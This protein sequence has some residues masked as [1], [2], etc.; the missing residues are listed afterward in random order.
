[1]LGLV[2][3]ILAIVAAAG[4]VAWSAAKPLQRYRR[5]RDT[6]TAPIKELG[7]GF[8]EIRGR[9]ATPLTPLISP[10]SDMPCVYY[11]FRIQERRTTGYGKR[12]RT[13]WVTVVSDTRA[14]DCFLEQGGHRA[15]VHIEHAE[16]V[17]KV[18]H[19]GSSGFLNSPT[20]ELKQRL[21]E[22]YDFA[23]E[24]T[25]FNRSLRYRETVVRAGEL[26]YVLGSCRLGPDRL[27]C[28]DGGE[29]LFIVA[30]RPEAEVALRFLWFGIAGYALAAVL[31]VGAVALAVWAAISGASLR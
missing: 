20:E 6:P 24:G 10:Y 11:S 26:L 9:V 30:D 13:R 2:I 23:T 3:L 5:I 19:H 25:L 22:R 18:D 4:G 7:N 28:F 15:E 1:M 12:R 27:P 8:F 16:L 29:D 21:G 17:L 14:A 31:G